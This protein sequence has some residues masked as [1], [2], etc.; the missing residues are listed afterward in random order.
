MVT[1]RVPLIVEVPSKRVCTW[2]VIV[3]WP[4]GTTTLLGT[5]ATNLLLLDN[6]TDVPVAG[7]GPSKVI[8]AVEGIPTRTD[9]GFKVR[10]A[11]CG[12]RTVKVALRVTPL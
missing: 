2:T 6:V 5:V 7:A 10:D 9:V 4:E 3:V 12:A 1:P 11:I 8:V